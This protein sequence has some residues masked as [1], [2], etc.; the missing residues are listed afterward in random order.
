MLNHLFNFICFLLANSM[1][2]ICFVP[3]KSS[4]SI[5]EM[6]W[7]VLLPVLQ[8]FQFLEDMKSDDKVIIFVG[9]KIV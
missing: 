6:S 3:L 7:L 4:S 8:L 9:K 1:T 2:V 5:D